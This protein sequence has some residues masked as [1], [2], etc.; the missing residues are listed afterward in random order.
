[1]LVRVD[2]PQQRPTLTV[3]VLP[4]SGSVELYVMGPSLFTPPF[5]NPTLTNQQNR[6]QWN[7]T[8]MYAPN[9]I[10]FTL[11]A[12]QYY[13]AVYGTMNST[14]TI[15]VKFNRACAPHCARVCVCVYCAL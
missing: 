7:S 12:A 13:I 2:P 9:S 1:M 10:T 11:V 4:C 3:E 14:Y 5:P 6:V 15:S 8:L